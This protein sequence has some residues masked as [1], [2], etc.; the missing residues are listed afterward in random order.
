M[1]LQFNN[2]HGPTRREMMFGAAAVAT[3][4]AGP[5]QAQRATAN[6]ASGYVFEDVDGTGLRS[7]RSPG[8]GGVMVSNGRDVTLS[9]RDGSWRL[10]MT[11]GDCIFVIKPSHWTVTPGHGGSPRFFHLHQPEGSPA[12][13]SSRFSGVAATGR[14]PEQIDFGLRRRAEPSRFDVLLVAD[15]QPGNA[16][17]LGF[18]QPPPSGPGGMLV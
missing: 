2:L 9:A 14:L 15:T 6:V 3:A 8:I 18:D 10:P 17:E 13:F 4:N 11:D 7:S 12:A 1:S 16:G 5:L